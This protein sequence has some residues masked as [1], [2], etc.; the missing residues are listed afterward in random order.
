MTMRYERTRAP[1]EV[2]GLLLQLSRLPSELNACGLRELALRVIRQ[3]P[4]DG[5]LRLIAE[6]TMCWPQRVGRDIK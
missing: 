3:Y 6:Q 1:R 4:D 5:T 2:R